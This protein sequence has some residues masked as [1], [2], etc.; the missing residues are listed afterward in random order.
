MTLFF[1]LHVEIEK[2]Q[3]KYKKNLLKFLLE[4]D[5]S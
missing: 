5:I 2:K 3:G 4:F 1:L